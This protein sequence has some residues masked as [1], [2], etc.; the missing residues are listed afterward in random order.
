MHL[1]ARLLTT[2]GS[3]NSFLYATELRASVGD[4]VDVYFQ[5]V[6][7][8]QLPQSQAWQPVGLRYCPVPGAT[9]TVDVQNLDDAKAFTRAAAQPFVGDASIWKLQLLSTDP[10]RG[11]TNLRFR[12]NEAGVIRSFTLQAALLFDGDRELC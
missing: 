8:D 11:T 7:L 4:P 1:S 9:M 12:L 6:D 10:L 2:V 3:V 5:L